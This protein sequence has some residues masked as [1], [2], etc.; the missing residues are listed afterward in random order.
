MTLWRV[1]AALATSWGITLAW[2]MARPWSPL[3]PRA[4]ARKVGR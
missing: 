1:V 2:L 3:V 4:R